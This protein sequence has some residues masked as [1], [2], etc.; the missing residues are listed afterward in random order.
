[1]S[2]L[3][4]IEPMTSS[5]TFK[6]LL[7]L[8]ATAILAVGGSLAAVEPA[9]AVDRT[10]ASLVSTPQGTSSYIT[11]T[12][13]SCS[14]NP[15]AS[16]TPAP[17]ASDFTVTGNSGAL[18]VSSVTLGSFI[19]LSMAAPLVAGDNLTIS[20]VKNATASKQIPCT[21]VGDAVGSFSGVT[22]TVA[23]APPTITG[24][25]G[26]LNG[27][28]GVALS[29]AAYS[30]TGLT[31][32]VVFSY[33][34][35]NGSALPAGVSFNTS[36]GQLTGTPTASVSN[37]MV[38]ITA[39]GANSLTATAAFNFTVTGGGGGGGGSL[40]TISTPATYSIANNVATAYDGVWSG[41][42]TSRYWILCDNAHNT[43]SNSIHMDCFPMALTQNGSDERGT[44]VN[45]AADVWMGFSGSRT[46]VSF[47][48]KYF[49]LYV[50]NGG[51]QYVTATTAGPAVAVSVAAPLRAVDALRT[52]KPV[53]AAVQPLVP[54]FL[55]LN[56]PMASLGGKVALSAGDFTGLVSAKIAGKSLD[57][58]LGN[59]GKITM[60]VPQGEAGKTAD[61]VL[62]FNTGSIIL[63]D[64]I[65]YVAPLNIA[66]VGVRPISIAAGA[67]KISDGVAD[68]I[69]QAAFA[70]LKNDT[71]QCIAYSANNSSAAT[72]AAKLTAVQACA[73]AVKA[74]PDLKVADVAVIVDKV[75]A[76]TQGVG[77]KVYKADN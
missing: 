33:T 60:T 47:A 59:T 10:G 17:M 21:T 52:L 31:S 30:T 65:K 36:T 24:T 1:M 44:T 27:T 22:T 51:A 41:G 77:I 32:P 70:N 19:S 14:I 11:L 71:I 64:A 2:G 7:T 9:K 48:S 63:Q 35:S 73:V 67:K 56:K 3:G 76:R 61:L 49:A 62:T 45:L 46:Q 18:P 43:P 39:T 5:N 75:K 72:A 6:K 23:A 58:I 8:G 25:S 40:Y 4:F 16:P 42:T 29:M 74:N 55:A 26:N 12:I 69:R 28:V 53:P 34:L 66:K 20:Y 57:F 38:S 13:A 68:Q 37:L 50:Q 15:F 54:G